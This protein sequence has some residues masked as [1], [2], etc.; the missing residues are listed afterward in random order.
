VLF[1]IESHT[2]ANAEPS[3]RNLDK[4]NPPLPVFPDQRFG[5]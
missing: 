2:T 3:L 1:Q 5:P 4:F